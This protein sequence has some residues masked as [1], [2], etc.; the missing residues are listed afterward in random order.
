V[1]VCIHVRMCARGGNAMN[2]K[3]YTIKREEG[4]AS[5]INKVSTAALFPFIASHF[6]PP[7]PR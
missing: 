2:V 6:A 3:Q 5:L 7:Y 1:C 4:A